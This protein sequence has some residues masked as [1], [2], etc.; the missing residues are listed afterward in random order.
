MSAPTPQIQYAVAVR[1]DTCA[2]DIYS[3]TCASEHEFKQHAAK[4]ITA[5]E[6]HDCKAAPKA[7]KP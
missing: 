2:K 5:A 3:A 7:A 6:L 4:A 1:C